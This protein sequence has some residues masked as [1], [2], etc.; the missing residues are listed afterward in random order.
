[1]PAEPGGVEGPVDDSGTDGDLPRSEATGCEL[2][3]Q[4]PNRYGEGG[5]RRLRPWLEPLLAGVVPS[6]TSLTIRLV[7]DREMRRLNATYRGRDKTTDVLSFPGELEALAEGEEPASGHLGDVVVSMP[8]TRRQAAERGH[9]V[10]RELRIL[11][12]HGILHCMGYDHTTDDGTM[13]QLERR[14]RARWIDHG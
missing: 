11:M 14:L 12:L 3:I 7:G 8:T 4:N 13:E 9:G 2:V 5:A 6:A 1:M 10:E